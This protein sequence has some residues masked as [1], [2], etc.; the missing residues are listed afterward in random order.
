MRIVLA[1]LMTA[2]CA[3]PAPCAPVDLVILA[4]ELHVGDGSVLRDVAVAIDDGRVVAIGPMSGPRADGDSERRARILLPGLVAAEVVPDEATDAPS[5]DARRLAAAHLEPEL[6]HGWLEAGVTSL[7]LSPGSLRLV[8]GRGGLARVTEDGVEAALA[9][10][11]ICASLSPD[12]L[13]PP[14]LFEPTLRATVDNP[15]PPARPQRPF[16][17]M[18]AVAELRRLVT[19]SADFADVAARRVPLRI[20]A[21]RAEDIARAV[22]L[23]R[24]LGFLLVVEGGAEA[25]T[26]AEDLAKAKAIV[27]LELPDPAVAASIGSEFDIRSDAAGLLDAAGVRVALAPRR[28]QRKADPLLLAAAAVRSGLSPARA[29]AAITGLAAEAIG[30]GEFGLVRVGAWADLA[31]FDANPLALRASPAFVVSRGR[32]V[33]ERE[34]GEPGTTRLALRAGRVLT[35]KGV[36]ADGHVLV[37]GERIVSVGASAA[38]PEDAVVHDFGDDAVLAPG[39][40]DAFGWLGQEPGARSG[41]GSRTRAADALEPEHPS[42]ERALRAGVTAALVAPGSR[43][44]LLGSAC[45]TGTRPRDP[46]DGDG[47]D[48]TPAGRADMLSADAGF[49]LFVDDGPG[50]AG[51][52]APRIKALKDLVQKAKA[53]HDKRAKA[54]KKDKPAEGGDKKDAAKPPPKKPAKKKDDK[55]EDPDPALEPLRP[56]FGGNARCWL[57]AGREDTILEALDVLKAAGITPVLAGAEEADLVAA[58]LAGRGISVVLSPRTT[59]REDGRHVSVA[60]ALRAAGVQVALGSFGWGGSDLLPLGACAAARDGLSPEDALAALTT[61]AAMTAGITD[62]GRLEAGARADV[63]AWSGDPMEP[64]SRVLAVIARGRLAWPEEERVSQ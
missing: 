34:K 15:L 29:L 17:A 23:Q 53:Y 54:D 20:H 36:V 8:G 2:A 52:R 47:F 50:D 10:G 62:A 12:A 21:D 4:S 48:A 58:E 27:V 25:W 59:R 14:L 32:V 60:A 55:R 13:A 64:A 38:L 26:L 28:A 61:T 33:H 51:P 63:V 45:T 18:A 56:L 43:G 16:T 3:A 24:E 57:R 41:G 39:F 9:R 30:A 40:I 44:A 35:G 37:S 6:A 7:A 42:M 49:V 1:A 19:T 22:L 5:V 46:A 31:A 11:A